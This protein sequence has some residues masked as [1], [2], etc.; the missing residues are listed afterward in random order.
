[1][2][3]LAK[4]GRQQSARLHRLSSRQAVALAALAVSCAGVAVA[5]ATGQAAIAASLLA[6]LLAAVPAGVVYLA[7]RI[8]T[9]HLANQASVRDLRVVVE[10][11]QR[12]VVSAIEKERLAAG[13]RHQELTDGLA[14]TDR[15][16]RRG[17]ELLL[18]EQSREIEALLQLFQH[19]KPRAP[20]PPAG[21]ALNPTDLLGLLHIV[22]GRQPALV[23][24][25]GGAA[26]AVWLGYALEKAGGRLVAVDHDG[27]H[28]ERTR[29]LLRAH[30]LTAVDVVHAPFTELSVDGKTV[31]WYDVDALG[32]LRDIDLLVVEGPAPLPTAEALP[33]ALHVLGRRLA[34]GAVVV[35]EDAPRADGRVLP[36]QN[37]PLLTPQRRLAGRYT[38]WAYGPATD[39]VA[40]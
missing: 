30:G 8:G 32:G 12:R 22:R 39:A 35:A 14:R 38:A 9:L 20:M 11:L 27:Q 15:L 7:R 16:T 1:M 29:A 33:P 6:L 5:A 37:P 17:A 23:V 36:R 4:F 18:R 10:Q 34:E 21:A 19:V 31:D 13:D 3:S 26:S 25:L 28:V 2:S 40:G 24:A